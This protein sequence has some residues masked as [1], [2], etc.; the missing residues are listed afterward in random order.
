MTQT[1]VASDIEVRAVNSRSDLDRFIK[2]PW[3]IY[4]NDPMWVPP[5][6]MD[7]K[8][9]LDRKKHPFHQHADVE[10]FLAWR[11][12]EVVGRIAAIANH[13]HNEFHGDK[14]GF[15]GFFESID[16]QTVA[17]ALLNTAERYLVGKGLTSSQGPMNFSTN[18]EVCSPGVMIDGFNT[19]PR[20]MMGH[21]PPYYARLLENAGYSKAKDLLCY[22]MDGMKTPERLARGMARLGKAE[23]IHMR[24]LNLKDFKGE[25]ARI[26]AI[27]NSAW[28]KNWGFVP[29]TDAEFE[30]MAKQ[31]KPIIDP[32]L[33]LIAEVE[34]KPVAFAIQ[35]PDYNQAMKHMNGR[36][37]PIGVFK[38]LWY[39]RKIDEVRV[40]TLGII[41][42]Y[43]GRGIDAMLVVR[44]MEIS[45]P[46]GMAKGECSWILED[47]TM[48]RHGMERMGGYVYK[49][50]RVF[51]KPLTA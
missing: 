16:D 50:Y 51:E 17:D 15:F 43:R 23:G 13:L 42:A 3:Q 18:E 4:Q 37:F 2:F 12:G 48:M 27:Y 38:F 47:N 5:L 49:T 14:T 1:K 31:L 34:G 25:L 6:L 11:D 10:Y 39:K 22:Y 20:I 24:P 21:T 32:E 44:M 8:G 36:L 46:R 26:K 19:P 9:A 30:H 41:P 28:E 7:V 33:V 29:M 40:L 45:Q 35:L